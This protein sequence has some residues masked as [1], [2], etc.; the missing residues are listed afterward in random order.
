MRAAQV[1]AF[2]EPYQ[3]REV[4]V[5]SELQPH[6]VLIKVAVASHCHTDFNVAKG[7]WATPLPCTGSHE[8][9]GTVVAVGAAVSDSRLLAVGDRVMGGMLVHPC[10]SCDDC[11]GPEETNRQYCARMAGGYNGVTADGFFAE[12]VRTDARHTARLPDAIPLVEASPLACAGR[13]VWSAIRRA[14]L[15]AGQTLAI[16]GSGG[17][18]GHLA[19]RFAK[20]RG[21]KVV[22][23]DVRDE[24]L[25]V[26]R[27]S[28]ADWVVDARIGKA[29][30]VEAVRAVTP[31]RGGADATMTVS[32]ARE[33]TALAC[34]VTRMHGTVLQVAEPDV[35]EIPPD[36]L[37][38]RDIRVRSTLIASGDE[39]RDM[40]AFVAEHGIRVK[41]RLFYELDSIFDLVG[42]AQ[43]SAM[44]GK[45]CLVID[46]EQ[47]KADTDRAA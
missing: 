40:L 43:S 41:T 14:G 17:G 12:Y 18:L 25:E 29:A 26:S 46:P 32:F 33:S 22:G 7:H 38:F 21:L 30:V 3:I 4:P 11:A 36:E 35:V 2:H 42:E 8:G 6:D 28:G 45:A 20:A 23:I 5:P 15:G 13:T 9:A 39:S 47:V 34:A 27:Q 10:G 37:V 24:G 44:T 16:V 19:V 31:G 1:V